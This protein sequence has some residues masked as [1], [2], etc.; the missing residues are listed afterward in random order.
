MHLE[1]LSL[2]HSVQAI[3]KIFALSLFVSPLLRL[4][5][6]CVPLSSIAGSI[7]RPGPAFTKIYGQ[8]E[9]C[10]L[11]VFSLSDPKQNA[12]SLLTPVSGTVVYALSHG[13]L[14]FALHGSF[15]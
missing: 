12:R 5:M 13:G 4:F 7:L 1:Q 8:Y 14:G 10:T 9:N 11:F 6:S 2:R 3:S 15:L